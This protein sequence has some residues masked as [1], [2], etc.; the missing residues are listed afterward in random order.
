MNLF[1]MTR[2]STMNISPLRVWLSLPLRPR[3]SSWG[4]TVLL[5]RR[6]GYVSFPAMV[7]ST[8]LTDETGMHSPSHLRHRRPLSRSAI[9]V[10]IPPR[11][12]N[13]LPL[14]SDLGKPQ[15]DLHRSRFQHRQLPVFLRKDERP[16]YRGHVIISPGSSK[17][18]YHPS[19]RL[20]A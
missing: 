11:K 2:I 19:P 20:R 4:V 5:S 14:L 13:P 9:P 10:Q 6:T 8:H 15:P 17:R 1:E 16:R 3:N 18:K 7:M 12:T